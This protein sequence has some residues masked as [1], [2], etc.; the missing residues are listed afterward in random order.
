MHRLCPHCSQP[1]EEWRNPAPTVDIVILHPEHGLVLVERRNEPHG[2][3]LP[4]GFVDYNETV[5]DAAMREAREE[6]G[7]YVRLLGLLGVYSDPSR[8]PR[9]HTM[10]T[11][12]IA[13]TDHPET[14]AAGDDAQSA[15]FHP[16]DAL[17]PLVFDHPRIIGHAR[18]W[19]KGTRRLAPI[20]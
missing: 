20:S 8:D 2:F 16:L 17:P 1:L 4:G 5:E 3:A 6:T 13:E 12:F 11:V 9:R 14:L 19:L 18:D 10:S 15:A 7:L